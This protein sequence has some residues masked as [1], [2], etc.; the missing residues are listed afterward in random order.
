MSSRHHVTTTA[1]FFGAKNAARVMIPSCT[2][3]IIAITSVCGIVG[4]L[5]THAYTSSKHA[6]VG[7]TKNVAAEL[8]Q[9]QIRMNCISP[10]LLPTLMA[11]ELLDDDQISRVY[12][13]MKGKSLQKQDVAEAALFLA[14]DESRKEDDEGEEGGRG[15]G[16]SSSI[17][18]RPK[19][20]NPSSF[21]LSMEK[22]EVLQIVMF[23]WLAMGHLIPFLYLSKC[24]AQKGHQ[25]SFVFTHT[26][27]Q[28]L[29]K[30]PT[31]VPPLITLIPL[32]F[33]Q[34]ENLPHQAESSMDIPFQKS[35]FLKIAFDSL[36][37]QLT[38][39]L[40]TA[41][42]KPDWIIFDYASHWLPPLADKLGI[43]RQ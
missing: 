20:E 24:L 30:I 34:N 15:G 4:G 16:G 17:L 39:F 18:R 5:G 43:S 22:E 25:I 14:S 11:K 13:N 35:Q 10:Y 3:S 2:G 9:F 7:I 37:S 8:G 21:I 42:P 1:V 36:E 33:P 41:D 31:N 27:L 29:P 12:H 38:Q 23:P 40:Q 28:R 26:N 19:K 6:V 32:S